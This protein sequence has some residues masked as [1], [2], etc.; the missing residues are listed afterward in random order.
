M[1]V[2]CEACGYGD[3]CKI[4][5]NKR[6]DCKLHNEIEMQ[7]AEIIKHRLEKNQNCNLTLF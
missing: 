3:I 4:P 1:R 5:E 2:D 7:Y 6:G